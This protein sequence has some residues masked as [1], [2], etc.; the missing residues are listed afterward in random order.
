MPA[1]WSF[2][3]TLTVM[4]GIMQQQFCTELPHMELRFVESA[5]NPKLTPIPES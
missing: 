4:H 1:T 2:V 3:Q 5:H